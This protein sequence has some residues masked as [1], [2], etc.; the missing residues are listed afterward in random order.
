MSSKTPAATGV[1]RHSVFLEY[2]ESLLVTVILALFFTSFIVQAYQIPSPSM[3][4]TLLV[5]DHLLVN[6]FVFGGRGL[7]Y[8]SV[9]PYRPIHR[10]DIIVF[11]F[12]FADHTHYVKRVIGL[13]GDRLRIVDQIVYINGE[14]LREPYVVHSP[15]IA[16]PYGDNFPPTP[17]TGAYI[18]AGMVQKEWR[19][20]I[21]RHVR[22]EDLVLPQHKFFAMGD[23]RDR[24]WDSRY[25]G[26]V[27]ED[28]IM[29]RPMFI[30]WSL[31]TVPGDG[32]DETASGRAS[33]MADLILH[34][35]SR[36]RWSRM[37]RPV[38]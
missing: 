23:N 25:W 18:P 26:F 17:G 37:F 27:D 10:E 2:A 21:F 28:A 13:P 11:K 3:E 32:G 5:G 22:G 20:E 7:W 19:D 1:A 33:G 24:S 36:T 38:H 6:K 4:T 15:G 8:E 30:Y 35:G 12:P 16:E 31:D 14:L 34:L 9:L 29:G